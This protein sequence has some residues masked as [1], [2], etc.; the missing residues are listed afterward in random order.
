MC[1]DSAAAIN[2][3]RQWSWSAWVHFRPGYKVVNDVLPNATN[4]LIKFIHSVES[5]SELL[6]SSSSS[7]SNLRVSLF[8]SFLL[9]FF[10]NFFIASRL[11]LMQLICHTDTLFEIFPNVMELKMASLH[12][13]IKKSDD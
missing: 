10:G 8:S 9:L 4:L 1:R 5:A 13:V 6:F 12:K 2:S 3:T 7:I 11:L